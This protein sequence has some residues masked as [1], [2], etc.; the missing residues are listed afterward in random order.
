MAG[1]GKSHDADR[2]SDA[3]LAATW[4]RRREARA[5]L[6]CEGMYLTALSRY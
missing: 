1:S 5:S 2:M 3:E 6:A 4:Q